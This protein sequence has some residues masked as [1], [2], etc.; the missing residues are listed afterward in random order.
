MGVE[1]NI[2]A[3]AR[4]ERRRPHVPKERPAYDGTSKVPESPSKEAFGPSHRGVAMTSPSTVPHED[5]ARSY[6]SQQERGLS[7]ATVPNR[8]LTLS[9]SS[10]TTVMASHDGGIYGSPI[11][12]SRQGSVQAG[13]LTRNSSRG[14]P[15]SPLRKID[16][17]FPI[18]PWT[19]DKLVRPSRRRGTGLQRGVVHDS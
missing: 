19:K 3:R 1:V 9:H 15:R 12:V 14:A 16:D 2:H 18:K 5:S 8:L 10:A 17:Y 6:E 13:S 4:E 7:L 11:S